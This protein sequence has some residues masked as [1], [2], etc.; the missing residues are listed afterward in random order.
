VRFS[1]NRLPEKMNTPIKPRSDSLAASLTRRGILDD[2]FTLVATEAPS[3]DDMRTWLSARGVSASVGALHNL[4]TYH[5]G[6]W[7][8]RN[9][10]AAAEESVETLPAGCDDILKK[11]IGGMKLDLVMRD[12]SSQQQLAVWKLDQAERDLAL[13][14][15]SMREAA[16]DA[17][18]KEAEGNDE[19]KQ[20]LNEF[21]A[22][23]EKGKEARNG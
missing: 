15:M 10:I 1:K 13:R 9:A 23:L 7:N 12:L 16:V 14:N 8:A 3:Y 4:V 17:L 5:M 2:F 21:L 6:V 11:R 18:L 22:A 19:A 20:K